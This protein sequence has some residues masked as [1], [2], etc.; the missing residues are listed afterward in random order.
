VRRASVALLFAV[1]CSDP[2]ARPEALLAIGLAELD[3]GQ[4]P[5]GRTH[6]RQI[7][8]RNEGRL[9]LEIAA[10]KIDGASFGA[11]PSTLAVSAGES[12]RLRVRFE[13]K[14]PGR[15]LATM[16]FES[17]DARGS[18]AAVALIG[19][20][21]CSG[22]GCPALD[23]GVAE[24]AGAADADA[25][26]AI[27]DADG[28]APPD[29]APLDAEPMDAAPIDGGADAGVAGLAA[30]YAFEETS[31]ALIDGSGNGNDG[32]PSSAGLSRGV[33]GRIGSAVL[34]EGSVG[35]FLVPA[36]P[37]LD[38]TSALSIELWINTRQTGLNQTI[39]ARGSNTGGDGIFLITQC[40]NIYVAFSRS[41][42]TGAASATTNCNAFPDDTWV[43][44]AVVND[45]LF[46]VI[47]LDG[48][49][50][51]ETVGGYLGP[52]GS[53]LYLG[54][55]EPGV[56]PYGGLLDE[57]GWWTRARSHAEVCGSLG[58]TFSGGVCTVP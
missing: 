55:K 39:L 25:D 46:L 38:G 3:F 14:S 40:N 45:G 50:V 48:Q 47:Y 16:S 32:V 49:K 27:D 19:V 56:E 53:P 29:A 33:A 17:N 34:F 12:T 20:G 11:S 2:S 51:V 30:R 41:G 10:V 7:T 18:T 24:D 28:G 6:T 35:Q 21:A 13:P 1:A 57:L 8:V 43:H 26:A 23:A 52:I 9:T 36:D 37:T 54:R 31:G 4:V 15:H 42:V 58:G 22:I 5:V 44:V